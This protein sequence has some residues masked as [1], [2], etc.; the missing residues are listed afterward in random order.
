MVLQSSNN[1]KVKE[2][3]VRIVFVLLKFESNLG[4]INFLNQIE[5]PHDC[6]TQYL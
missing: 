2:L 1:S 4:R 3:V 5:L 6:N